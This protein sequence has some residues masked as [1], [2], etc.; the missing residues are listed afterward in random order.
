[1]KELIDRVR[2][3]KSESNCL[4]V[5]KAEEMIISIMTINV[6]CNTRPKGR[7]TQKKHLVQ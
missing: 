7:A 5:N 1:M 2:Q 6:P 3:D 4:S